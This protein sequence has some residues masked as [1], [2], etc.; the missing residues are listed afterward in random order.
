MTGRNYREAHEMIVETA[1]RRKPTG[2]P[3]RNRPELSPLA[4][5]IYGG[6][7]AILLLVALGGVIGWFVGGK[8]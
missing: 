8:P 1:N 3:R 2:M 4:A 6:L 7:I 5:F